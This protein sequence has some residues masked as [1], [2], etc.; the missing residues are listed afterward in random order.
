MNRNRQTEICLEQGVLI[1]TLDCGILTKPYNDPD[2]AEFALARTIKI[3]LARTGGELI[4]FSQKP[5][6]LK[7]IFPERGIERFCVH[8]SFSIRERKR[9]II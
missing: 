9:L 2:C 6:I 1:D 4:R 8:C 5:R 3:V 7:K